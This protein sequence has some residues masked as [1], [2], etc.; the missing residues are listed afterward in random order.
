MEGIRGGRERPRGEPCA[1]MAL[2]AIRRV[3]ERILTEILRL[4]NP[5]KEGMQLNDS[6]SGVGG[7]EK[8]EQ[9]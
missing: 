4:L 3:E 9:I 8:I 6:G 1:R 7:E 2:E 5:W